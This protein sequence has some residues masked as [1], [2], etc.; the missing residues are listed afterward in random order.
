MVTTILHLAGKPDKIGW[1]NGFLTL[2]RDICG[3]SQDEQLSEE[4]TSY[5]HR[6]RCPVCG[7]LVSPHRVEGY[8][9]WKDCENCR[10]RVVTRED[11][12][13]S[14]MHMTRENVRYLFG[15][16][17]EGALIAKKEFI[18]RFSGNRKRQ[19]ADEAFYIDSME[20]N[21]RKKEWKH[22]AILIGSLPDAI[23][24]AEVVRYLCSMFLKQGTQRLEYPEGLAE[25]FKVHYIFL[26][27]RKDYARRV[28]NSL[29]LDSKTKEG[30]QFWIHKL[31]SPL[32]T[33][34]IC[35]SHVLNL[36]QEW[37]KQEKCAVSQEDVLS[38]VSKRDGAA[39]ETD[40]QESK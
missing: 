24:V 36:V 16:E 29:K 14:L 33:R 12:L 21:G 35:M 32:S 23:I 28:D 4:E 6:A 40:D 31:D 20:P 2:C 34:I 7:N 37:S 39:P 8:T 11:Q 25:W 10:L 15:V 22:V 17:I 9:E 38:E 19:T 3:T 30:Y 27:D 5:P 1:E 18:S 13:L 26:I